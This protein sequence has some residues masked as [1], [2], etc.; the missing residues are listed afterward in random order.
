M[1]NF[2]LP[3]ILERIAPAWK[4]TWLAAYAHLTLQILQAIITVVLSTLYAEGL[5]TGPGLDCS[6]HNRWQQLWRNHDSQSIQRIQDA[7]DC[8]GFLSLRDMSEPHRGTDTTLCG[9][10]YHRLTPCVGP[11]GRAMQRSSSLGFAVAVVVGA[12]QLTYIVLVRARIGTGNGYS[13]L[14]R[15]VNVGQT[16]AGVQRIGA[17]EFGHM[18]NAD[19]GEVR[20]PRD[21]AR[22][23][24]S[25][26]PRGY[27]TTNDES[28][29]LVQ[30][31]GLGDEARQWGAPR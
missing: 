4:H 20:L 18:I 19:D 12:I 8:C 13:G 14:D 22:Y 23:E 28:S 1:A 7:F 10:T 2:F 11:W 25:S 5:L 6:L 27:G 16:G 15:G 21:L 29:P 30:P 3:R 24:E 26:V 9:S 17:G 31:S